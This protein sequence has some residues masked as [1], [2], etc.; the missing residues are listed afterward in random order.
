MEK[1]KKKKQKIYIT[2]KIIEI[3]IG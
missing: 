2:K 1:H 3:K